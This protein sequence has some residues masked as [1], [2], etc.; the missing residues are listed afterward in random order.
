MDVTSRSMTAAPSSTRRRLQA[1]TCPRSAIIPDC[2]RAVSRLCL[3]EVAGV[4]NPQPACGTE[5]RDGDVVQTDT[6]AL[7]AFRPA[8]AEWLLARHPNDCMRCEV[9]ATASSSVSS[10]RTSG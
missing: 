9:K 10:T 8:D 1:F 2:P 4:H 3:V 5:A 7:Q 6:A